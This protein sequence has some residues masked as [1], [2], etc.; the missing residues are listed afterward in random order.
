MPQPLAHPRASST[1]T[2]ISAKQ[3]AWHVYGTTSAST[4]RWRFPRQGDSM[5]SA[6][7][8]QPRHGGDVYQW[9]LMMAGSDLGLTGS[10]F[11]I[12]TKRFLLSIDL[13]DHLHCQYLWCRSTGWRIQKSWFFESLKGYRLLQQDGFSTDYKNIFCSSDFNRVVVQLCYFTNNCRGILGY[14]FHNVR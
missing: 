3:V 9:Q 8:A 10:G 14:F 5:L 11:F 4:A 7:T 12:L 6:S 2:P 13:S 1:M